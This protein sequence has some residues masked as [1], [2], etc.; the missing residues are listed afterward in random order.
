MLVITDRDDNSTVFQLAEE[1]NILCNAAD[2]PEQCR[3][4]FGSVVSR[5]DLTLGISTNGIAP[6]LAVRLRERFER[7]FG[8]EYAQF[9]AHYSVTYEM[10][11][12]PALRTF[13]AQT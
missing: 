6:A 2:D 3:F 4:S 8:D 10:K 1:R 13:G 7:E 5:G 12:T 9:L 11:S